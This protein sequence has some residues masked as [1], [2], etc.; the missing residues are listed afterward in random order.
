MQIQLQPPPLLNLRRKP[1]LDLLPLE[2]DFLYGPIHMRFACV[3]LMSGRSLAAASFPRAEEKQESISTVMMTIT[4]LLF[5]LSRRRGGLL[6]WSGRV[7][8]FPERTARRVA[9]ATSCRRK[10]N[11][12]VGLAGRDPFEHFVTN[13]YAAV[14]ATL[15]KNAPTDRPKAHYNF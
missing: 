14:G 4:S 6:E 1:E 2:L 5:R 15:L 11:A 7:P 9:V 12:L 3:S 8:P 10:C 13:Q